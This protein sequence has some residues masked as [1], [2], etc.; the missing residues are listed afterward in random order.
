MGAFNTLLT[1]VQCSDCS[2]FFKGRIQFKY[3]DTWQLEYALG[4]KLEWGGNDIGTPGTSRVKVYGSLENDTCPI[5][6]KPNIHNEFDIYVE[7]DIIK[8][9]EVMTSIQNYYSNDS[10]FQVIE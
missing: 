2:N 3:G 6:H 1:D 4:G 5:C 8:K 7:N 10:N 9:A